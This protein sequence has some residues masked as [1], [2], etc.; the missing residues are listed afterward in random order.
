MLSILQQLLVAGNE[1][2]TSAIAGGIYELAQNP[3]QLQALQN[4]PSLIPNAI[5]EIV[6]H[7][8]P[9]AGIWR[10]VTV[11][12]ELGGV[13]IPEG[14]MVMIRYASANRDESVFDDAEHVDVCRHN[15]GDNLAFGQGVHFC[16][17]AQ[18][19][20]KEMSVAF[21]HLIARTANWRLTE[22]KNSGRH[23]PNM[24]LRGLQELH[25]TFD[26]R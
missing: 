7:Q 23:W 26:K 12:T 22:G 9:T 25:I 15:A 3:G 21:S 18:L 16:L 24:L 10:K 2:T 13:V 4:D 14:S 8:S 20:R 11:D 5:E 1:T 6:R 17:G 19:A